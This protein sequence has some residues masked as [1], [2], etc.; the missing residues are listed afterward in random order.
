MPCRQFHAGR[1]MGLPSVNCRRSPQYGVGKYPRG[2]ASQ[3]RLGSRQAAFETTVSPS[4]IEA[5]TLGYLHHLFKMST[6]T[7]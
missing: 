4:R 1:W 7:P 3:K 5:D 2:W 6:F